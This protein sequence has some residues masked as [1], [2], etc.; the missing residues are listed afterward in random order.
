MDDLKTVLFHIDTDDQI[1]NQLQRRF[2]KMKEEVKVAANG[3]RKR[4]E[5]E[6]LELW[7]AI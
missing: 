3:L 5:E 7:R 2:K 6:N 1:I 4:S